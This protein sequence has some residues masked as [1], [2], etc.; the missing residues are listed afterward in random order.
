[1]FGCGGLLVGDLWWSDGEVGLEFL[2]ESCWMVWWHS[3]GE[4]G[5]DGSSLV[6][7]PVTIE[8]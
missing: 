1:M 7:P 3:R 5:G 2:F 8:I 4:L 6:E